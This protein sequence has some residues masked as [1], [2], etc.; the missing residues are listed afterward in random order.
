MSLSLSCGQV[1]VGSQI[2]SSS[3]SFLKKS[4]GH[5]SF[6]K[7]STV[8][9]NVVFSVL[10]TTANITANGI[11][12]A[13]VKLVLR[14]GVIPS[15]AIH[16]V[17]LRTCNCCTNTIPIDIVIRVLRARVF[18][19]AHF[20]TICTFAIPVFVILG[21]NEHGSSAHS[22]RQVQSQKLIHELRSMQRFGNLL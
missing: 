18:V 16:R 14:A 9:V 7:N 13:V 1:S 3:E 6:E 15:F 21:S 4:N 2:P 5:T 12:I 22:T 17:C 20:V 11:T 10:G 8:A 19:P